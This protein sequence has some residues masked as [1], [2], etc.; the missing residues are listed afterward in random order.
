METDFNSIF[1]ELLSGEVANPDLLSKYVLQLSAHLF[2]LDRERMEAEIAY[3]KLWEARRPEF[4]TDK[5]AE[6]A[7]KSTNEWLALEKAK[8][9]YRMTKEI[10]MSAKKRLS[11]LSDMS[12]G[13]Y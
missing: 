11:V 8:S 5:A 6:Y 12:H 1:K 9:T 3:A 2:N 4:K 10:V 7:L 13:S